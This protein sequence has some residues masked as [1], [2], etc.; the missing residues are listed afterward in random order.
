MVGGALAFEL[1]VV[2]EAGLSYGYSPYARYSGADE[3]DLLKAEFDLAA[4]KVYLSLNDDA[5]QDDE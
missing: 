5:Y 1:V 3:G 4:S 2:T